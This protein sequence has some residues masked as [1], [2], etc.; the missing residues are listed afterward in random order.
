MQAGAWDRPSARRLPGGALPPRPV[1]PGSCLALTLSRLSR[2]ATCRPARPTGPQVLGSVGKKAMGVLK[3][4]GERGRR[5]VKGTGGKGKRR[6]ERA[7]ARRAWR[8]AE[9]VGAGWGGSLL[10]A[11]RLRIDERASLA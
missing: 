1:G 5:R 7:I 8:S 3:G 9:E 4:E 11:E 6:R 10:P 2:Q